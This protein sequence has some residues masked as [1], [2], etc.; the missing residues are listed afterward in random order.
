M[1]ETAG[2]EPDGQP[3]HLYQA[4][5]FTERCGE[6]SPSCLYE[7]NKQIDPTGRAG[8]PGP[9]GDCG[10]SGRQHE[11]WGPSEPKICACIAGRGRHLL[12]HLAQF[13]AK[14]GKPFSRKSD[15]S[16]P[17]ITFYHTARS[18]SS[19]F[20]SSLSLSIFKPYKSTIM[21]GSRTCMDL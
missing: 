16:E 2:I 5:A 6:Q 19:L 21:S 14:R 17:P 10:T 3:P 11:S 9:A 18:L 8:S 12:E 13:A 7:V 1:V 15:A 4:A 20:S